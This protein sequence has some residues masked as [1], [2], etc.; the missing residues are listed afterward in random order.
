[1]AIK[2]SQVDNITHYAAYRIR[3]NGDGS[4]QARW[5]GFDDA[6]EYV[7]VPL[8]M[9]ASPGRV[10]DRLSNF[11]A[12]RAQ[13]E[14]KTTEIDEFFQINR[15]ILWVKESATQYPGNY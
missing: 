10:L 13:L 9:A 2:G 7:M 3:V 14:L 4:L 6:T 11:T 8:T 1:M 15:I 12:Q 5:I